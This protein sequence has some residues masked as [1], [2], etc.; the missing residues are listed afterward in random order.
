MFLSEHSSILPLERPSDDDDDDNSTVSA[1]LLSSV[2]LPAAQ[3]LTFNS[4][5]VLARLPCIPPVFHPS[6]SSS[7]VGPSATSSAAVVAQFAAL[8]EQLVGVVVAQ[9]SQC[10]SEQARQQQIQ[11]TLQYVFVEIS[12]ERANLSP[13]LAF[14]L[15]RAPSA[16]V[17]SCK[18]GKEGEET[19]CSN[20][21]LICE[22]FTPRS[23]S[24]CSSF[25]FSLLFFLTVSSRAL[26]LIPRLS[27]SF[28]C[29]LFSLSFKV[30]S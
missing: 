2:A 25:F 19:N 30:V 13:A 9:W 27:F 17:P 26:S 10:E 23:F 21:S 3:F 29:S 16:L 28:F 18:W 15:A 14:L 7:A 24:F 5:F 6:D 22:M 4:V 11:S 20:S 1:S 8:A 12:N